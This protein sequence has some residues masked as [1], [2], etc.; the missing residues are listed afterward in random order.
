MDRFIMER[1]ERQEIK[2][3]FERQ[4]LNQRKAAENRS[5]TVSLQGLGQLADSSLSLSDNKREEI[6]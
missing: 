3:K 5:L 1:F 6:H 2:Q 4:E